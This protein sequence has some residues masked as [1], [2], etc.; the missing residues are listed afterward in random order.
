[1]GQSSMN[2][3]VETDEARVFRHARHGEILCR[4]TYEVTLIREG[5]FRCFLLAVEELE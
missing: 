5:L 3:R 4:M 1:M 2:R